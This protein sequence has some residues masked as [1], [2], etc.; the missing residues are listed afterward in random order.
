MGREE[1]EK[2]TKKTRILVIDEHATVREGLTRLINDE[3]GFTVA[4]EAENAEQA[5]DT[6]SKQEVDLVIVDVS[7]ESTTG[8]RLTE[9]IKSRCPHM[10]VLV[11]PV[12]N[13]LEK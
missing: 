1:H 6:I 12:S 3:P 13:F 8:T 10:P 11:L 5:L 7:L 9:E 4:A 2:K